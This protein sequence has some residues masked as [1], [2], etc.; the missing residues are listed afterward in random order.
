MEIIPGVLYVIL[1]AGIKYIRYPSPTLVLSLT[2]QRALRAAGQHCP[3]VDAA[4]AA[5][6]RT[7]GGAWVTRPLCSP[8]GHTERPLPP[9]S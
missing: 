5:G 6:W 1:G 4:L 7:W 3:L 2:C 9:E 8:W